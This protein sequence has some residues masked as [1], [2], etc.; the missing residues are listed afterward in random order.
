MPVVRSRQH[1][2]PSAAKSKIANFGGG[3]HEVARQASRRRQTTASRCQTAITLLR[4]RGRSNNYFRQSGPAFRIEDG[5]S[6]IVKTVLPILHPRS[7]ILARGRG[8]GGPCSRNSC[9]TPA[10]W[11]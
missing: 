2:A 8:G 4:R 6:R 5:G 7:S 10:R 3:F 9:R 1:C 11:L